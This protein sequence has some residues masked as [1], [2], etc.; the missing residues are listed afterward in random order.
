MFELFISFQIIQIL[1]GDCAFLQICEEQYFCKHQAE[2]IN[3]ADFQKL[4]LYISTIFVIYTSHS[5]DRHRGFYKEL[6]ICNCILKNNDRLP[7]NMTLRV[8]KL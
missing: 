8:V 4:S 1:A 7:N 6:W 2:I 5:A 3:E